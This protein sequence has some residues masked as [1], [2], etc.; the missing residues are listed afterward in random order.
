[1]AILYSEKYEGYRI[2]MPPEDVRGRLW[3]VG[4]DACQVHGAALF[5]VDVRPANDCCT[6]L[7]GGL[8]KTMSVI[9]KY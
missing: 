8:Q 3:A 9:I 6:R 7:C 1:M 2:V 4:D 5:Q